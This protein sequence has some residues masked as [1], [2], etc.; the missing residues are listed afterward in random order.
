MVNL[1]RLPV[2]HHSADYISLSFGIN[3]LILGWFEYTMPLKD[4]LRCVS[5]V[6]L[7]ITQENRVWYIHIMGD[8]L[9]SKRYRICISISLNN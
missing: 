3:E 4:L 1:E 8:V 6:A 2:L 9:A 7:N 5:S